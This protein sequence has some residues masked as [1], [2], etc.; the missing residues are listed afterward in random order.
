MGGREEEGGGGNQVVLVI[1]EM[2]E[3]PFSTRGH[4]RALN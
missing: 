2:G 1:V 4:G 3:K